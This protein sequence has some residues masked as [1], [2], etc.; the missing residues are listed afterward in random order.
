MT[1]ISAVEIEGVGPVWIGDGMVSLSSGHMEEFV[2]PLV[3]IAADVKKIAKGL[4]QKLVILEERICF[5]WT[6]SQLFSNVFLK[7]FSI[8]L[9]K[10]KNV[11]YASMVDF[12]RNYERQGGFGDLQ[13][14]LYQRP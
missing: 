9:S 2:S 1:L 12:F 10:N 5:G 7:E 14:F 3:R 4:T 11:G 8:F 6:G 13:Y